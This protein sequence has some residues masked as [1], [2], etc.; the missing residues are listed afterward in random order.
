MKFKNVMATVVAGV[1]GVT[2]LAGCSS[3]Q[4]SSS[5]SES[6]NASTASSTTQDKVVIYSTHPEKLLT[7]VADAFTAETGIQVEFINLKGG[8][9]DR[10]QS[11]KDNPQADI[12]YGGSSSV[13]IEL[14]KEGCFAKTTPNWASE[15]DSNFKDADGYWYGTIETPVVMY[16][17]TEMM[18]AADAPTNYLDLMDSK[19]ADNIVTRDNASSSMREWI[20]NLIYVQQKSGGDEA[21]NLFLTGLASNTKNYYNSGSMMMKAVGNKEAAIGISTLNDVMDNINNN[22]LPLEAI[23]SSDGNVVALDCIA[24]INNAP[25]PNAAAKFLEF[26]GSADMQAKLANDLSRIPTLK[27]A[28]ANSPEWMQKD[29]KILDADWANIAENQ[30]AW[31]DLWNNTAY[32]SNKVVASS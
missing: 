12:M 18:D 31:L 9:A 28:I 5:S 16:Y 29:R 14:A 22:G 2:L 7:E 11:E 32:D 1:L 10:V 8:L 25:H 26:A 4:S 27:S 30:S 17:N 21:V 19:Y 23:D 3:T 15:L 6:S 20:C 24:A 13:Y